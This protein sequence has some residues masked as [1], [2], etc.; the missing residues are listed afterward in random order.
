MLDTI[1]KIDLI[2]TKISLF[3]EEILVLYDIPNMTEHMIINGPVNDINMYITI[4][5]VVVARKDI[6]IMF[7]KYSTPYMLKLYTILNNTIL[8]IIEFMNNP[9]TLM[10]HID[11]IGKLY[12][13]F[14]EIKTA[15]LEQRWKNENS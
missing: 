4:K 12:I 2:V 5:H 11:D 10:D 15:L 14:T 13:T 3:K 9:S 6:E 8:N 1:E 7:E